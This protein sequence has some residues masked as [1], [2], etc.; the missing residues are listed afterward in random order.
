MRS[1][2]KIDNRKLVSSSRQCSSTP[3]GFNQGFLR[4][5]QNDNTGASRHSLD[6]LLKSALKGQHS[7]NRH[8]CPL[9]EFE[10]SIP[11][12]KRPQTHV[13]D[14]MAT[15][16]AVH[17][18]WR[19]SVPITGLWGPEGSGRSRHSD[20]VTSALEGGRFSAI[21]TGRLY[22]QEYSG[23]HFKRLSRPRAH[24]VVGF[25]GKNP[26]WHHGGPISGPSV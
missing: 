23:T 13:W 9:A 3:V 6:S 18:T 11:A 4:K 1:E 25:H 7:Q 10:P 21:R 2:I 22:P 14:S 12:S 8:S 15:G 16:P 20:S 17:Y 19:K 24:G 5:E 26:Q